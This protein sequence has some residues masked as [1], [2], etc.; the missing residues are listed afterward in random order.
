LQERHRVGGTDL[1]AQ[2]SGKARGRR[3][4]PSL[5][6]RLNGPNETTSVLPAA[7]SIMARNNS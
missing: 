3:A 6:S 7:G 5:G 2:Q 1:I 4:V